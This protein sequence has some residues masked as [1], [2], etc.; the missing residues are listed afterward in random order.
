MSPQIPGHGAGLWPTFLGRRAAPAGSCCGGYEKENASLPS[1]V[2]ELVAPGRCG[3]GVGAGAVRA[4]TGTG[5]H[6]RQGGRA[7]LNPG[8]Q[9]DAGA[10]QREGLVCASSRCNQA[11]VGRLGFLSP[12][13]IGALPSQQTRS[14]TVTV[15]RHLCC[16]RCRGRAGR[17]LLR[18]VLGSAAPHPS[19]PFCFGHPGDPSP[20]GSGSSLCSGLGARAEL[21]SCCWQHRYRLET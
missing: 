6:A 11:D 9:R 12:A 21:Q 2:S 7:L 13:Q 8:S 19:P 3:E 5:I 15:E 4:G 1:P 20:G 14:V 17:R 10:R 16:A 18:P